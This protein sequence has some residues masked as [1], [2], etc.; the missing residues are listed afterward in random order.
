[1][2]RDQENSPPKTLKA[3]SYRIGYEKKPVFLSNSL[4]LSYEESQ[5]LIIKQQKLF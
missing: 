3:P 4:N 1:M 5:V 2:N